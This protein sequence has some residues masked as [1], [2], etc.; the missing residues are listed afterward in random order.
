MKIYRS[1]I[2][3]K[4]LE[5]LNLTQVK[6][7]EVDDIA[8]SDIRPF[9]CLRELKDLSIENSYFSFSNKSEIKIEMASENLENLILGK[10]TR[11]PQKIQI[12]FDNLP[13]LKMLR[14]GTYFSELDLASFKKLTK[15]NTD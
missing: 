13:K 1:N 8:L 12:N 14:L 3:V 2:E 7:Y 11:R 9:D 15:D 4:S 5:K 10:W 6:F